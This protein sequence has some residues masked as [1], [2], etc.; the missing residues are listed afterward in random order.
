[1]AN[2]LL[3]SILAALAGLGGGAVL[4]GFLFK[5]K[6]N[7]QIGE[8]KEKIKSMLREAELTAET[9]K[10]DRMLEAKEKFLKLKAESC[11]ESVL[12]GLGHWYLRIPERTEPI[13]RRF[14]QRTDISPELRKYAERAAVG[15]VQ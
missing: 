9:I 8:T 4:S 13:V 10:K 5:N 7:K 15:R 14:L 2:V 6:Q 12:H 1:M 11:L 3:F